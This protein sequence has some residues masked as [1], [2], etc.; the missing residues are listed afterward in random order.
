MDLIGYLRVS[1]DGQVDAYGL[2]TQEEAVRRWAKQ[3]RHSIVRM[4]ADAGVSGTV[5]ALVRP[6]LSEVLTAI[7]EREA[8]GLAVA[9][10]DRLARALTVQEATLA[11]VWRAGGEVFTAD[12]G[13]VLRDDPDDPMRTALRQVVGV[14]AELDRRMVV[15]RLRDGRLAKA[16]SGRKAVGAYPYGFAATGKGRTRD[17]APLPVEQAVV[18]EIVGA[19]ASGMTYR[20]IAALL[21]VS[22]H[23]P[24]RAE[25]WSPMTIRSIV[26]R[27]QPIDC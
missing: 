9:P 2:D 17:A 27:T 22:P 13:R 12:T 18:A 6:G 14:F 19:R 16:A 20:Q 7:S 4:V 11:V 25:R 10:L 5:D 21:D 23:Q 24:R 8:A 26:L 1:S 15:K 3:H